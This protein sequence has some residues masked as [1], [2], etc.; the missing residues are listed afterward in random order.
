M[1]SFYAVINRAFCCGYTNVFNLLFDID[2]RRVL[3]AFVI[4][5]ILIGGPGSATAQTTGTPASK[6]V[7]QYEPAKAGTYQLIFS[8]RE[9]KP[10]IVPDDFELRAIEKLRKDDEIVYAHSTYSDAVKVRIMPRNYINNPAFKPLPLY[11]FKDEH[12]YE[13]YA[14]IRYVELQ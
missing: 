1:K 12:P 11:Y 4:C 2:K 9:A 10:T 14:H 5:G 3:L 8:T 7:S 6:P 13:E